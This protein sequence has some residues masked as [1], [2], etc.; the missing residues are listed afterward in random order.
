MGVIGAPESKGWYPIRFLQPSS[1]AARH[2]TLT[3]AFVGSNPTSAAMLIVCWITTNRY[4]VYVEVF[5][6]YQNRNQT[7]TANIYVIQAP[8]FT[9]LCKECLV[10][11]WQIWRFTGRRN[12]TSP[13]RDSQ[14][15]DIFQTKQV[16]KH[17]GFLEAFLLVCRRGSTVEQHT[18]VKDERTQTY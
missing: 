17:T 6:A 12:A 8:T 18:W 1:Q 5:G 11:L 15:C 9:R 16:V 7:L 4:K 13:E 3:P 2:G 10:Q 14:Q